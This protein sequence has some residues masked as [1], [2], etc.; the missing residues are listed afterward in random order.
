MVVLAAEMWRS[1]GGCAARKWPR[2]CDVRK[3]DC[4]CWFSARPERVAHSFFCISGRLEG[5]K[6]LWGISKIV[7]Q[8]VLIILTDPGLRF[9]DSDQFDV[10]MEELAEKD[11]PP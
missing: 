3:P 10:I 1:F 5:K 11:R 6:V 7:F 9:A 8:F 4:V 2:C